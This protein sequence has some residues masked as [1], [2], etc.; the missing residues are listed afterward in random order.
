MIEAKK[1]AFLTTQ[2]AAFALIVAF[3]VLLFHHRRSSSTHKK[4]P[5][6]PRGLPIVG[7]LFQ[8]SNDLWFK[9]TEWKQEYGPIMYLNLA[10]QDIIVLNSLQAAADLL[11]RR[12]ANYS[13]RPRFVVACNWLTEGMFFVLQGYTGRWRRMRRASHEGLHSAVVK[14][15]QPVQTL[16]AALLL[17]DIVATPTKW[18]EHMTRNAGSTVLSVTYD[19]PPV[20]SVND[21]ALALLC[22]LTT[23]VVRAGYVDGFLVEF[24]PFLQHIP[25]AIAP[26]KRDALASATRFTK[27][28]EDLY[29]T[30]KSR[31]GEEDT[32]PS[33]AAYVVERQAKYDLSDKETAWMLATIAAAFETVSGTMQ[34]FMLAMVLYPEAQQKAQEELDA[35]VG[36]GRLPSFDDLE[37]LV[38]IRAMV[39]E[40]LRWHPVGP[41]GMQHKSVEDDYYGDY[42]IPKGSVCIPNVWAINRDPELWGP[43]ADSF[44]PERHIGP[45]GKLAPSPADTKEEGHVTFGFGR[46]ICVGRH[47]GR[48]SLFLNMACLLWMFKIRPPL[49]ADGREVVCTEK[50]VDLGLVVRPQE[51]EHRFPLRFPEALAVLENH[52]KELQGA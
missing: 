36:R 42:F 38:Y 7:N 27:L 15:F 12:A 16:E 21:P 2:P 43:D 5:P 34:W 29:R 37:N 17:N 4:L 28:F 31:V 14:D 32:R 46:R 52:L 24:V 39:K 8:L 1:A 35:V 13:H 48:S 11:D 49:G 3:L 25:A 50:S 30:V 20:K 41:L 47:V 19:T 26:W 40:T 44:R 51:Y 6:G 10:G 22:E 9:L 33:V 45:D 23:K 18:E